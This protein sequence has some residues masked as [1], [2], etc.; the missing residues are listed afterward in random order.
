MGKCRVDELRAGMVLS[1]DVM[2]P[3][4]RFVM[5]KGTVLN[6]GHL[7][8]LLA[9]DLA[10]VDVT[11]AAIPASPTGPPEAGEDLVEAA[12]VAVR[13]RFFSLDMD[14]AAVRLLFRL[15]VDRELAR[16]RRQGGPD[17]AVAPAAG[18]SQPEVLPSP[19]ASLDEILRDEPQLVSP[20]EVYQRISRVLRDPASTVDDAAEA[21]RHDPSLAAKLLRLVNSPFYARTMRAVHGRFPA[22]VDSLSRAVLVVGARQLSTLALGVSVLPLF[23]DI[24]QHWVNMR[25]FWEHSVG[26]AVA[27]Q[28][29]AG[30]VGHGNPEIAFVAGLVHDLGR[31]ILFKQ[32]PRHMAAAM[33]LAMAE[34]APLAQAEGRVFGF[35]HAALG[36]LLLHKWQFPVNLETMV[37]EH[38]ETAEVDGD[39]GAAV[40]HLADVVANAMAWGSSGGRHVPPLSERAFAGLGLSAEALVG[41]VPEMEAS[42]G[43]TMRNFFPEHTGSA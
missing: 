10:G 40:I 19:P 35:D 22:K 32:A 20:P 34:Q 11:D 42:L 26:C 1:K 2:T 7:K 6:V 38:H 33:R 9:W 31:I 37:R 28:A 30:A 13:R 12:E 21:L 43:A 3:G 24:P 18:G 25:L 23:Q 39:G 36:G 5:P 14:Q 16:L 29:I 41:L 17:Q 4:G 8:S 15:A 27:A